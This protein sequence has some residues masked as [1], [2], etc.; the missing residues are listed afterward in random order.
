M[1]S[2]NSLGG[3]T[4]MGARIAARLSA[5]THSLTPSEPMDLAGPVIRLKH[6]INM[7]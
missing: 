3:K 6:C 2:N 1:F 5:Y 4:K 7:R